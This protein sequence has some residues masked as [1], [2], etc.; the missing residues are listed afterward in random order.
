M[1]GKRRFDGCLRVVF[2]GGLMA[3]VLEVAGAE[4]TWFG[5]TQ[6]AMPVSLADFKDVGVRSQWTLTD[7]GEHTW[8]FGL[9]TDVSVCQVASPTVWQSL[10][11]RFGVS[12]RF[13][14]DSASFDLWAAD[15]R[16][17]GAWGL[18]HGPMAYEL[19]FLHE[20]SHL[21]D[22][23]Q[24]RSERPRF[25]YN[26]N[27]FRLSTSRSWNEHLRTYAGLDGQPWAVPD[28]LLSYGFLLGVEATAL[29]PFRR[30]FVAVESQ[31]WEWRSFEPDATAQIGLFIGSR[32]KGGARA[33]ARAYLEF[34][35][36]RVRLGQFFSETERSI[37]IG[38][39][40]HW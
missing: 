2:Y 37:A 27:T 17:G 39:A 12:S 9:G 10:T 22:E 6:R 32:D 36:G 40:T 34:R 20:S 26:V 1:N 4:W 38:L 13:Q 33:A 31:F 14:F 28:K 19:S 15:F 29:P 8:D 5:G 18:R 7:E 35:S 30:G 23:V 16:G 3:S 24:E 11:G 21:G 25:D